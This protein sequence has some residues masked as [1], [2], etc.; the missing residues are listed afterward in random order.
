MDTLSGSIRGIMQPSVHEVII[1]RESGVVELWSYKKLVA[2]FVKDTIY[3]TSEHKTPTT[4]RHIGSFIDLM[5]CSAK[6]VSPEQ[7]KAFTVKED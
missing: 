1:T 7:L 2:V 5:K 3:I 6:E 4:N